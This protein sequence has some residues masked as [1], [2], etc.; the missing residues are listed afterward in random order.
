MTD[1]PNWPPE[2]RGMEA[3]WRGD[4]GDQGIQG[5]QGK[6]GMTRATRRAFL[7]LTA[8]ILGVALA[9]LL[10]GVRAYDGL[11]QQTRQQCGA[12]RSIGD[13]ARLHVTV[14]PATHKASK[15]LLGIIAA[16][17][18][19]WGRLGCPGHLAAAS[20]SYEQWTVTY[21]LPPG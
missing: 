5:A 11:Q 15:Q 13:L 14:N 7:M 19:A 18:M 8:L 3:L 1:K 16:H 6:P 9:G 20:P 12:D 10:I 4:K 21:Q 2:P 17:R